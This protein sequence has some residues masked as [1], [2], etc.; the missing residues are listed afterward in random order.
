MRVTQLAVENFSILDTQGPTSFSFRG[1]FASDISAWTPLNRH[2]QSQDFLVL[3]I[4]LGRNQRFFHQESES[5]I[6]KGCLSLY[7]RIAVSL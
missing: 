5:F 4:I 2:I 7:A 1:L 6:F 3:L